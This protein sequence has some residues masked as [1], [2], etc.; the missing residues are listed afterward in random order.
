MMKKPQ[1]GSAGKS[2]ILPV[3]FEGEDICNVVVWLTSLHTPNF[4]FLHVSTPVRRDR[5]ARDIGWLQKDLAQRFPKSD[6]PIGA[7]AQA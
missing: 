1:A 7:L 6:R 5:P 3:G 4:Q 2:A